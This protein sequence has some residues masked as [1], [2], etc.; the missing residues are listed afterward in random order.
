MRSE[1]LVSNSFCRRARKIARSHPLAFAPGQRAGIH[2]EIHRQRRLVHDQGFERRGI[3]EFRQALANL[4]SFDAGD[5]DEV[6]AGNFLRLDAVEAEEGV[7]LRDARGD[8][9][10][11]ALGDAHIGAAAQRAVEHAPNGDAPEKIAVVQ[12]HDLRL[13]HA[14]R[15]ALR[16][17]NRGN[18]GFK[19]RLK[20]RRAIVQ[21]PV[22]DSRL[23]VRVE[24]RKIQLVFGGFEVDEEVVDFVEHDRGAR[25]AA[26]NFVEHNDGKE[27]RLERLL[28]DVA[29]LGQ[30]AFARVHQEKDAVHHF[31]RALD[32]SAEIAVA[33]SVHD[34]DFRVVIEQR[35]VF[36]QDGDAALAL[37]IVRVHHALHDDLIVAE[38]AALME[39]GVHQRG[40][41]VVHVGDDGDIANLW[42]GILAFSSIV[43]SAQR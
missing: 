6:A 12:I 16:L 33:G 27:L 2:R 20:I 26:V 41:P 34:I 7:E 4:N 29:R 5:G 32:F 30:R 35:R 9:F 22:R 23:R 38:H 8:E 18:N 17:G 40:F 11:R 28:Q 25:I 3:F 43:V 14:V 42:H 24:H 37:E 1:T 10:S 13:Q 19:E 15:I 21:L 39:H 31:Q 36:R